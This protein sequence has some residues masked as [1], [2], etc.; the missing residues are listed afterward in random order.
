LRLR[1]GRVIEEQS[2]AG[3]PRPLHQLLA[4][5]EEEAE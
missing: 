1:D 5:L 3:Q 4:G 2:L